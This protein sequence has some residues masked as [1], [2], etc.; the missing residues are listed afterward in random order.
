MTPPNRMKWSG[1]EA[2]RARR[3]FLDENEDFGFYPRE[4]PFPVAVDSGLKAHE[5]KKYHILC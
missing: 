5:Y 2:N 1:I 3:A 4:A